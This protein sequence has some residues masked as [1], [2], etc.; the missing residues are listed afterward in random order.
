VYFDVLNRSGSHGS[1]GMQ[2]RGSIGW[3]Y[4]SFGAQLFMNYT[5]GYRNWGSPDN[6]VITD[7][8][9]L[10][11]SGGGDKVSPNTT[12]D[13]NLTYDFDD[14]FVGSNQLS[15]NIRNL[16]DQRPPYYSSTY[17]YNSG[18]SSPVGRLITVGLT[19]RL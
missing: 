19:S 3:A 5:G 17:G 11:P 2:M 15:L 7:P 1:I 8:V 13:M 9:T 4:E 16:F 10:N 18:I 12:F 6:P 14:G